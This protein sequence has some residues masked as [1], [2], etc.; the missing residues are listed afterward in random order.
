MKGGPGREQSQAT[1]VGMPHATE[2][3]HLGLGLSKEMFELLGVWGEEEYQAQ[4]QEGG[5]GSPW[6]ATESSL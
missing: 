5:S 3:L 4:R 1:G 6:R 2:L